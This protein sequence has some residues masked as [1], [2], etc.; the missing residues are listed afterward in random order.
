MALGEHSSSQSPMRRGGMPGGGRREAAGGPALSQ[1][2]LSEAT[3]SPQRAEDGQRAADPES[4]RSSAVGTT[5]PL[6]GQAA[7]LQMTSPAT[8]RV[9]PSSHR[10][11]KYIQLLEQG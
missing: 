9:L 8:M 6:P 5:G 11:F 1:G 4:V 10:S 7:G 2:E 3:V